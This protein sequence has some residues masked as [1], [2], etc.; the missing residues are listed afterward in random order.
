L[1]YNFLKAQGFTC[2]LGGN[3]GKPLLP[4]IFNI[5]Y[6]H[7][8]IVELSS[9][10]LQDMKDS[11]YIAVVTNVAPNHLDWHKSMDEY[12]DA[13]RNIYKYQ[14]HASRLTL[15]ADNKITVSFA[16]EANGEV[17][18]FSFKRRVLK[19]VYLN[20]NG[21]IYHTCDSTHT[22]G[23]TDNAISENNDIL[24]MNRDIIKLQGDHNVENYMAA[25]S[26]VWGLCDIKNIT[27]VASTFNGV[28]HRME[29]IKEH[30]GVKYYNDSI[31]TSPTR[32]IA[33][34]KSQKQRIILIAGGYDKKVPFEPLA[35]YIAEKVKLLIL[36]GNTAGKI[37]EAVE[38]DAGYNSE[39][40]EIITVKNLDD[41]VSLANERAVKGDIVYLS[42]ASASFD[43]F[44]N[45][46]V[47][48][49]YFKDLVN[50]LGI[51]KIKRYNSNKN[52]TKEIKKE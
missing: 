6:D 19:G 52:V 29:F 40:L 20:E 11:P 50:S 32:T 9:F 51:N 15:N 42:P 2:H 24:I 44:P 5:S 26:A 7:F 28:E 21:D 36:T 33:C 48:G 8:A 35:P 30:N 12:I 14:R 38:K 34:L 17:N 49:V 31:A 10:Q 43:S 39:L 3:I 23:V 4:E 25:I 16:K 46:E 47:R 27:E 13:K 18:W 37:R 41:A 45:F 1:I 22:Y